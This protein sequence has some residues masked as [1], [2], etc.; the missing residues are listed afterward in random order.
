MS[1]W[2]KG[3]STEGE[4][5]QVDMVNMGAVFISVSYSLDYEYLWKWRTCEWIS[6]DP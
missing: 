5:F 6:T 1:S 2:Q 3:E 4:Y